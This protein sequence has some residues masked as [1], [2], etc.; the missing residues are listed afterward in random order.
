ME[1]GLFARQDEHDQILAAAAESADDQG[2]EVE[3][4]PRIGKG[5]RAVV[6]LYLFT[7][8]RAAFA[9]F[10]RWWTSPSSASWRSNCGNAQ[11][12]EAVGQLAAGLAHDFNN[13]LTVIHDMPACS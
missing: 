9:S 12:M 8:R 6:S 2:K 4:C 10:G 13:L 5:R 1:L 7:L 3:L 11:K